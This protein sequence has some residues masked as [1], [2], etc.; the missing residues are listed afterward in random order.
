L[1]G[2]EIH[3]RAILVAAAINLIVGMVWY[4][5]ALF[6]K[7]WQKLTGHKMGQ[8]SAGVGYV[9][10]ALAALVQA[11]IFVH[12]VRYAGA[13]TAAKGAEVGFWLW[14]A[15][16]AIIMAT[17]IVFEGRPWKLWAINAGY[18]LAVLMINGAILAA[19][20]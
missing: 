11:W 20:R 10:T 17:N 2:V 15:F 16:V 8:G 7:T 18:F 1:P 4:S 14:L 6:G 9:V 3:W 19:W 5:P 12:F 13:L